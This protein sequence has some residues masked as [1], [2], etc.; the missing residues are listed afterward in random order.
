MRERHGLASAGDGPKLHATPGTG[1]ILVAG[2][3][4]ASAR[5]PASLLASC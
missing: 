4:R 1:E 5:P 3:K 2:G